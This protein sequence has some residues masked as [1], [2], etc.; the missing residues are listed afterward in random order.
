MTF[1][2]LHAVAT[3]KDNSDKDVSVEGLWSSS[4]DSIVDVKDGVITAYGKGK[5]KVTCKFAGKTVTLQ[6]VVN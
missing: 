4:N 2:Q 6:I 5:A 1:K 3:F